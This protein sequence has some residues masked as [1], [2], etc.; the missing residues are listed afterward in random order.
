MANLSLVPKFVKKEIVEVWIAESLWLMLL[1]DTH[2]PNAGTQQF[3]ADVV[4]HEIVDSGSGAYPA[5]GVPVVP[6]PDAGADGNNYFLD[7]TDV[8]IGPGSNLNYRYGI[9]Y[10]KTGGSS[11]ADYRIRAQIDFMT[12]PLNPNQI[13]TNGTSMINWSAFGIIYVI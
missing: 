1:K 9:L 7:L 11:Q 3:V 13:V 5:G 8:S 2:T 6:L 12:D 4:A 10:T